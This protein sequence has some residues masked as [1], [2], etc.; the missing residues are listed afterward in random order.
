MNGLPKTS[1]QERLCLHVK[2]QCSPL[3]N[4][5]SRS[6]SVAPTFHSEIN[7]KPRN[8]ERLKSTYPP[9]LGKKPTDVPSTWRLLPVNS[10][11][12]AHPKAGGLEPTSLSAG[13]GIEPDMVRKARVLVLIVPLCCIVCNVCSI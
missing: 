2:C 11:R 9:L 5:K 12:S 1:G 6:W 10:V 7:Q 3:S 8:H 4:M 13:E